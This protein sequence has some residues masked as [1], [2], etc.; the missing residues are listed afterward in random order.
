MGFLLHSHLIF[1]PVQ[2]DGLVGGSDRCFK[3]REMD[4]LDIKR[5][6]LLFFIAMSEGRGAESGAMQMAGDVV[7]G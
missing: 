7:D 2:D 6:G 4:G 5:Y 3:F 1:P